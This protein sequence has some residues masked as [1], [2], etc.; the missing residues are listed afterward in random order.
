MRVM[1]VLIECVV[2]RPRAQEFEK[3]AKVLLIY[4]MHYL[5]TFTEQPLIYT[6]APLGIQS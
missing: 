5:L 3:D 4:P 6:C 1:A 2:I